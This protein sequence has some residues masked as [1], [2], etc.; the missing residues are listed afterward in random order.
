MHR[1]FLI[2]E[3]VEQICEE[4]NNSNTGG[5]DRKTLVALAQTRKLFQEPALNLVWHTLE[6]FEPVVKCL[7]SDMWELK[8]DRGVFVLVSLLES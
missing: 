8:E 6:S 3:L 7:P 1:C 5:K 4:V 2:P